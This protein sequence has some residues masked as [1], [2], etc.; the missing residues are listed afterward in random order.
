MAVGRVLDQEDLFCAGL[1]LIARIQS[2]AQRRG[3][4]AW[5]AGPFLFPGSGISLVR[6]RVSRHVKTGASEA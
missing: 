3:L 4:S 6:L 2:N 1:P 5:S